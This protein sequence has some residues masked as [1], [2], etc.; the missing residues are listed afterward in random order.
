MHNTAGIVL[1]ST[2]APT[3]MTPSA[4]IRDYLH[5]L[6]TLTEDSAPVVANRMA[7]LQ[8]GCLDTSVPAVM[9]DIGP[10]QGLAQFTDNSQIN[11]EWRASGWARNA[12]AVRG[13]ELQVAN[14]AVLSQYW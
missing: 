8:A 6:R 14:Q 11:N 10:N 3:Q 2:Y 7:L 9:I 4:P 12:E 5:L 1:E 13:R